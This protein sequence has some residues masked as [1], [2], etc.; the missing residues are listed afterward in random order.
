M[1]AER[2]GHPCE[3]YPQHRLVGREP[4]GARKPALSGLSS[5]CAVFDLEDVNS[6]L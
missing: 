2:L 1:A 6:E 4:G 3:N 5:K